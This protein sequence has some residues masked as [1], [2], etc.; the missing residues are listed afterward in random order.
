MQ[1]LIIEIDIN[2]LAIVIKTFLGFFCHQD[3]SIL[4][5][6]NGDYLQLCPRCIGLHTGFFTT[7]VAF[8]IINQKPH[9]I[10]K[11]IPMTILVLLATLTGFHWFGARIDMFD[12]SSFTRFCTGLI[13]G[14]AFGYLIYFYHT[15]NK[16]TF[17][18]SGWPVLIIL[19]ISILL[20]IA[21][22]IFER[23]VFLN[24]SL[25]FIV[26]FNILNLFKAL[27]SVFQINIICQPQLNNMEVRK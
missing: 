15:L 18:R 19:L 20:F 10:R 14:S 9:L 27:V 11:K 17:F 5:S 16:I 4:L 12:T 3:R 24:Y 22:L 1:N 23:S 6:M 21:T 2:A 13:S 25:G 8:V 26:F 7:I